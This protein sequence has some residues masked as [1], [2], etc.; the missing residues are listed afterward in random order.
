M[1]LLSTR[2]VFIFDCVPM[3]KAPSKQ[4][5]LVPFLSCSQGSEVG[6]ATVVAE[7]SGQ[8]QACSGGRADASHVFFFFY[9]ATRA[10]LW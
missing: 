5:L 3:L 2:I 4:L 6:S 7:S 10:Y 8:E 1:L 9:Q